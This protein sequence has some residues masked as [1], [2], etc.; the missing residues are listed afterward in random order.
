MPTNR[1]SIGSQGLEQGGPDL[2][3]DYSTPSPQ[4]SSADDRPVIR[5]KD[6]E[7]EKE[8]KDDPGYND[9]LP[10]D[11]EDETGMG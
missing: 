7:A 8:S 6:G 10:V 9:N 5:R 2:G 11:E 1:R 3:N 4:L